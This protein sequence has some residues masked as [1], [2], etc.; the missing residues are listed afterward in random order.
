MSE[1]H[2]LIDLPVES[3]YTAKTRPWRT[4]FHVIYITYN[5]NEIEEAWVRV[6]AWSS[7][8]AV[9][10]DWWRMTTEVRDD[11]T[12]DKRYYGTA[13]IGAETYEGLDIYINELP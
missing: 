6:P 7:N 12:L 3:A 13:C 11:L 2:E 8:L 4:L 9:R 5:E 10:I 1:I